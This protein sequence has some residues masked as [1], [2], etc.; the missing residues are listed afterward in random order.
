MNFFKTNAYIYELLLQSLRN[1]ERVSF[2]N[3]PP[4][5]NLRLLKSSNFTLT[6][7]IKAN[8]QG[9]LVAHNIEDYVR[10]SVSA[11]SII[12]GDENLLIDSLLHF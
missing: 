3:I 2:T 11:E 9:V 8:I 1:I 6:E 7:D 10:D 4:K 5:S 12:L